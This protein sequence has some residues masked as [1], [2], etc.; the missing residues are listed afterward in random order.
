MKREISGT[1][2][3]EGNSQMHALMRDFDWSDFFLGPPPKWPA[4]LRSLVSFALEARFPMCIS[5]GPQLKT[6]YN[7]AF[8]HMLDHKHP[9]ALGA[10]LSQVC[11]EIWSQLEP[12]ALQTMKGHSS[13]Y[14]NLPVDII[15]HGHPGQSWVTFSNSPVRDDQGEIIG[16]IFICTE[17]TAQVLVEKRHAFQLMLTDHLRALADPAEIMV[18]ASALLGEY[19]DAARV[20]YVEVGDGGDKIT[21]NHNWTNGEV[22]SLSGEAKSLS[23]FGSFIGET[24]RAGRM[25]VIDDIANDHRCTANADAYTAVDVHAFLAVPVIKGGK[26]LAVLHVHHSHPHVW[27]NHEIRL[28]EDMV[29]RTWAAAESARAQA[30]LRI[31]RDRSRY[32]FDNMTEGFAVINHDW[33]IQ[34]INAAGLRIAQRTATEVLG[35]NHWEVWPEGL[36]TDVERLYRRV[37]KTRIADRMEYLLTFSNGISTWF[38]TTAY[39]SLDGGLAV[40]FR[41]INERKRNEKLIRDAGQHDS[42]TGL[43]NRSLLEEYCSHILAMSTRFGEQGAL[44][45]I[46]LDRFKP[47]N[48]LYGHNVGDMVLQEVARRLIGCTRKEDIVSRLGGDEFIVILTRIESKNDPLVVAQHVLQELARPI[49]FGSIQVNVSSSIGICLFPEQANNLESLIRCA[50]LAMYSAKKSGRNCFKMY[51]SGLNERASGLLRLEMQLRQSLE[52]N[53]FILFYQPILDMHSLKLIGAEAL[54]RM[55]AENGTLLNPVEFIPIAET[56]G[57]IVRLGDW[58]MHEAC[59]QHRQWVE[60]GLPPISIAVNVSAIQ[61]RQAEFPSMV[62]NAIQESGIDPNCLQ[63]EVTESTLMENIPETVA[64]LNRLQ[65]MGVG[66]SL[67]DFGTGYSSLSYLSSLP[68]N[69]LKIDQSFIRMMVNSESSRSITEAIIGLGRTL[70]LK[71]VGEGIETEESMEYLRSYGCDQAQGFLFSKPLSARDFESW[72]RQHLLH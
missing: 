43:P 54:V 2:F 49:S 17:T 44:L 47:I 41:D 28:T 40:F 3:F 70:N 71:V 39:P 9:A 63:I 67:D 35:H 42:L 25:L 66:I 68:L 72:S 13:F 50:D 15:R 62:A 46:D 55:P 14:Q 1:N 64:K 34:Q 59:R 19:L 58:A 11:A 32:I 29:E 56:T 52:S 33:T 37:M 45:F 31:E 24:L 7:D 30:A 23:D 18:T 60:S 27:T 38:E 20:G 22:S 53:A 21:I 5:L 36:G 26:L 16:V 12:I 57:L 4:A 10:P 6:V 8:I 65:T 48:D 69:K 51:S 61:F